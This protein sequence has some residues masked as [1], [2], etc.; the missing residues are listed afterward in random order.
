M[1]LPIEAVQRALQEDG[2]DGW[3][4]YDFHGSN[5]IATQVAG[6]AGSGK[7]ATRRWYYL[8]PASGEPRGLV[9]AIERHNLDSL[10]GDKQPYA[11][12]QQLDA[13][14]RKLLEGVKRVAMEYSPGNNIPYL[15]RVDAGTI[16][17]IREL[18][19][20]VGSSGDLVQRFEAIWTDAAYKTHVAASEKLYA[21]KD[22][23][24]ELIRERMR[25]GGALNEYEV[26]Q[27]MVG[28]F[29]ELGLKVEQPN[30]SA[31]ENA[32]NPHY[33]PARDGSRAI[34][35]NELV[36]IDLWSKL[37][38]AGAVFADITWVG[39][40]GAQ[41][42][43]EFAKAFAAAAAGRDA[44]VELVQSSTASGAD[45]RGWQVDRACRDVI[46]RAGYGDLFIHRTGHSLGEEVHGNGVHMDDYET[47]D[48]RRLI[49]G[50]GFTI[51]PGV[52]NNRF[53]VRTEINMFVGEREASVT[54][55]LQKEIVL[56]G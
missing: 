22:R 20:E 28:W 31:Q 16:E 45:L 32:G 44:A 46:D 33:M 1:S 27:R 17:A 48:D 7:M 36:L 39:Y 9:H 2:F 47:R 41:V 52:Y 26:Q 50:T 4:L 35:P 10:P 25:S 54:G 5:P 21:V 51:E 18:G 19:I 23:T 30:V 53:G 14:L 40:T 43:D 8:I 49:A 15:S 42:P 6:L 56:I 11:G 34:R 24:F 12:R 38:T 29:Q 3:L 13:G 37:P 55:P